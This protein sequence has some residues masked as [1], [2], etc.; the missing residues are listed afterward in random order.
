[1]KCYANPPMLICG[2][3]GSMLL[4]MR[5][6]PGKDYAPVKCMAAQCEERH[7]TY[8][9]K[10]PEIELSALPAEQSKP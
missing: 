3:C 1:M 7:R 2:A 4:V 8:A 10:L 6:P 9:Y 5:T